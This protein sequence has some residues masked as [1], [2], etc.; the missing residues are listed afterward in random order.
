[1]VLVLTLYHS[2]ISIS[3]VVWKLT[4]NLTVHRYLQRSQLRSRRMELNIL[5][6]PFASVLYARHAHISEV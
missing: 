4:A 6:C 5:V 3:D 1:M 2:V